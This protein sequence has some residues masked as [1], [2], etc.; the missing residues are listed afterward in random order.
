MGYVKSCGSYPSSNEIDT[1]RYFVYTPTSL[2]K[3]IFH[4]AHDMCDYIE[5]YE[6]S[7]L[8]DSL[9]SA[10][11]VVC[12]CDFVGHGKT[13]ADID[14][15]GH[16][17]DCNC[18]VDDIKE[19]NSV[20]RKKYRHLPY[21]LFGHGMGSLIARKFIT[22]YSDIIDGVILCG[23]IEADNSLKSQIFKCNLLKFFKGAKFRS[24]SVKEM[25]FN[26]DDLSAGEAYKNDELCNYTL[27]VVSYIQLLKLMKDVSSVEWAGNVPLSLPIF[28][29]SGDKDPVGHNGA[30]SKRVYDSLFEAEINEL[31]IKIYE[32]G[33][34]ELHRGNTSEEL[35]SDIV[36]WISS[37][38]EGVVACD[39]LRM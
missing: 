36:S 30:D 4:I 6:S 14:S 20:M 27:T 2:A 18:M 37:V 22:V 3:A 10:G 7:G 9:T 8:I 26:T 12:G 17:T 32:E 21:V 39:N 16:F 25:F 1:V 23:T 29:V 38:C 19:L 34:H 35:F 28:I 11:I 24:E 13:A 31:K 15:L 5:R 33:G